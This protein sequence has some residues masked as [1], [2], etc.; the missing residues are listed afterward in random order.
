VARDRE[1]YSGVHTRQGIGACRT[2]TILVKRRAV[3]MVVARGRDNWTRDRK[4]ILYIGLMFGH[5]KSDSSIQQN[6]CRKGTYAIA[7]RDGRS[8]II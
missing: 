3:I 4:F 8:N 2:Q 7:R 1:Q 5:F 6:A